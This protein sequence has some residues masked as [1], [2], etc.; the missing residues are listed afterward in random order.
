MFNPAA[1]LGGIIGF[2]IGLFFFRSIFGALIMMFMGRTLGAMLGRN[3]DQNNARFSSWFSGWGYNPAADG[4][5][6]METLFS[7][8]GR[9]AAA[10]GR[11]S[12][13]EEELFRSVVI[14]E[15]RITD[16]QSVASSLEIFHRAAYGTEPMSVYA[17]RAAETFRNRPQLLE[18]MLIIMIR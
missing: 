4:P 5:A 11:V 10:D 9:L 3:N 15:L 16:P 14:N 6:F 1:T 2:F 7:M 17:R 12:P 13:Q 8:L 18:M